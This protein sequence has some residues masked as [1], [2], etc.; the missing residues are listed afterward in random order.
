MSAM[1]DAVRE[2]AGRVFAA[3]AGLDFAGGWS[4]V[5]AN[6]LA[7]MLLPENPGWEGFA[8][9]A[10]LAGYHAVGLPVGEAMIGAAALTAMGLPATGVISVGEAVGD[11]ADGRFTGV[12]CGVP[13][14]ADSAVAVA[15]SGGAVFAVEVRRGAVT[16]GQNVAG[17]AR[18]SLLFRESVVLGVVP[19]GLPLLWQVAVLRAAQS[20]GALRRALAL[21]I[22]H[23][24]TRQQFGRALGKFQAVQQALAVLAEESAACGSAA[25]GAAAVLADGGDAGL[26]VENFRVVENLRNQ[27]H[28][29][30]LVKLALVAGDDASAFLAAML[31]GIE[32]VV[33]QFG[34]VRM[35]ENAKNAAIMFGVMFWLGLHRAPLN[36]NRERRLAQAGMKCR[37]H[38]TAGC[39]RVLQ[40]RSG[41]RKF[42]RHPRD[43]LDREQIR[44]QGFHEFRRQ[45]FG[46]FIAAGAAV[47]GFGFENEFAVGVQ[48]A[49]AKVQ[50]HTLESRQPDFNR[51]QVVVARGEF[52]AELRLDDGENIIGFLQGQHRRAECAHEFTAR[53]LQQ[54]EV[55]R[56]VDVVADGAFGVADAVV[57]TEWFGHDGG[58]PS[59]IGPQEHAENS[60]CAAAVCRYV[61][62]MSWP[63]IATLVIVLGVA[64][65]FVWRSSGT[66]NHKHNCGC[67][68][69][70]ENPTETPKDKTAG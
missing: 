66:R 23:A 52:V 10:E 34:G 60:I 17:E 9:V 62:G 47:E 15:E 58:Q 16:R 42:C 26:A 2:S 40:R 65:F 25:A 68:C 6:G 41:R 55:A 28:A 48:D 14:G 18:D 7:G 46:F 5:A 22:E 37:R 21:S 29:V 3:V 12:V 57:V 27:T 45:A 11:L 31:E 61:G 32:P 51:Q 49:V 44:P 64:T 19:A 38:F 63:D 70:H 43:E 54:I 24:N 1:L 35:A 36:L 67:G 39:N 33:G 8:A 69:A 50:P 56:M 59:P 20:A 30:V 4:V 13:W 53:G